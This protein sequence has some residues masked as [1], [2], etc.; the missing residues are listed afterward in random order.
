[1]D[2]INFVGYCIACVALECVGN[3][4][5]MSPVLLT[6][7]GHIL[8]VMYGVHLIGGYSFVKVWHFYYA[9]RSISWRIL[10]LPCLF[11][12]LFVSNFNLTIT[13]EIIQVETSNLAFI[14]IS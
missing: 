6:C 4:K 5:P 8:S 2:A 12:G 7:H 14:C 13:F 3:V 9:P 1:V 10:F 11:V